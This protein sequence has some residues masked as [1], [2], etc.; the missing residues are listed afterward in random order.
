MKNRK[1]L[2]MAVVIDEAEN[3]RGVVF[4]MHGFL[5]FKEHPLLSE[6]AKIFKENN[7]TTILFDTT[8]SFGESYGEMEDATITGYSEDLED[9]IGETRKRKWYRTIFLV[10]HSMGGYCVADYAARNKDVKSLILFT[11]KVMGD[12]P[13]EAE[14]EEL[15]RRGF[16]EWESHSSPGIFKRKGCKYF[17][18]EKNCN[19]LKI[20]ENIKCPVLII[21]GDNDK[22]IPIEQQRMLFDKLNGKKK[23][24][25]VEN[26]D[27]N[28]E[29]WE[30]S[31][32]MADL[33][34]NW[35]KESI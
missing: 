6:T 17:E 34:K 28:L 31:K 4:L 19:L 25:I 14:K 33:I 10:G 13:N 15:E 35:I 26:G 21:S 30:K 7:F 5:S 16:V 11:P 8:N 22:V 27:H 9:L 1:G 3:S 32:E 18:E 2:D 23:I 12:I 29:G 20:A 24:H